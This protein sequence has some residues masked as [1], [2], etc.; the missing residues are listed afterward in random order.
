MFRRIMV[1]LDGSGFSE[2]ALPVAIGMA[3]GRPR[4]KVI[5]LLGD[6]SAMYSIQGLWSAVQHALPI[7]FIIVNNQ[8]YQAL[9]QFGAL[10]GLTAKDTVGT[11]LPG[12]DFVALANGMGCAAERVSDPAGLDA[13]LRRA[14]DSP[15]ARLL[16]VLVS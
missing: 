14:L 1:P 2:H 8:R 11:D 9:R 4:D 6:G 5:C 16:E 10:F 13:A 12:I 7:T 3:M 15:Q